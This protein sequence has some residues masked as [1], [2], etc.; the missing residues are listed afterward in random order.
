MTIKTIENGHFY[1]IIITEMFIKIEQLNIIQNR[2]Q[3]R[4]H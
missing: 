4:V 1:V 2:I 3:N